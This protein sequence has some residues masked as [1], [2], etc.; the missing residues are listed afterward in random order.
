MNEQQVTKP[1]VPPSDK[2]AHY[3]Y[4]QATREP[5]TFANKY[6]LPSIV[7]PPPSTSSSPTT[8]MP[9][10]SVIDS[11]NVA[12]GNFFA[13][14]AA[15]SAPVTITIS[16]D[17]DEIAPTPTIQKRTT[18]LAG[19]SLSLKSKIPATPAPFNQLVLLLK[20][21]PPMPTTSAPFNL[22][23]LRLKMKVPPTASSSPD[24]KKVKESSWHARL[25]NLVDSDDSDD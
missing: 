22:L 13:R 23:A 3:V 10:Q 17:D 2:K 16:D 7:A 25:A 24:K 11:L 12:I 20:V 18:E 8:T 4:F 1:K 6:N 15:K 5:F 14:E 9:S 19:F 21:P